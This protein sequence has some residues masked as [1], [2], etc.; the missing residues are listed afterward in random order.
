MA[1]VALSVSRPRT[2]T[3]TGHRAWSTSTQAAHS[4]SCALDNRRADTS[5]KQL[6]RSFDGGENWLGPYQLSA[7]GYADSVDAVS[8]TEAWAYGDHSIFHSADGGHNWSATLV[9]GFNGGTGGP[10]GFS[11]VGPEDAWAVVATRYTSLP[12]ELYRTTDGGRAWSLVK[13]RA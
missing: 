12:T 3:P 4:G 10:I 7:D 9:N 1:T 8:A 2:S 11:A 13:V 5:A 6:W